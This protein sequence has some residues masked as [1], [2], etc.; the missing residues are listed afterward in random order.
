MSYNRFYINGYKGFVE[1]NFNNFTYSYGLKN[2]KTLYI[3]KREEEEFINPSIITNA[4]INLDY[5]KKNITNLDLIFRYLESL[6]CKHIV[7]DFENEATIKDLKVLFSII[8]NYNIHEALLLLNYSDELYSDDFADIVLSSNRFKSII[9]FNSP[10]TKNLENHIYY[11]PSDRRIPNYEK[12]KNEFIPTNQLYIESLKYHSYFNRKL[13][14]GSNG[15]LKNGPECEDRFGYI[16]DYSS[17]SE[18]KKVIENPCFQKYWNAKKDD[19]IICRDCEYRYMCV[20]NRLPYLNMN[21]VWYHKIECNYNP[22]IAKWKGEED[23][24]TVKEW[25]KQNKKTATV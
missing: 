21:K 12:N 18:L 9:I 20:D 23:Y 15:E 10:F 22:Y 2:N 8:N 4:K 5:N 19:S 1:M 11:Y 13:F 24:M 14:I 6:L 3:D 25:Q 7:I 16:Q 17:F